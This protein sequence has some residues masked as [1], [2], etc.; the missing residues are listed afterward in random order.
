DD[1]PRDIFTIEASFATDTS[2]SLPA[3]TAFLLWLEQDANANMP[4]I[5]KVELMIFFIFFV[6]FL[7]WLFLDKLY[8][9][10]NTYRIKMF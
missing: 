4:R 1:S 5:R 7:V 8:L 10:N 2:C 6:Y 9:I 3:E